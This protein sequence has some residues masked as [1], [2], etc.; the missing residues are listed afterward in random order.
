MDPFRDDFDVSQALSSLPT[1]DIQPCASFS[2]FEQQ[3]IAEQPEALTAFR[4]LENKEN[5]KAQISKKL[6]SKER[7]KR[8]QS[9]CVQDAKPLQPKPVV[10]PK[11]KRRVKQI[12]TGKGKVFAVG[13]TATTCNPSDVYG[14][15]EEWMTSMSR[16]CVKIRAHAA[17]H[18]RQEP[19]RLLQGVIVAFDK[20]WNLILRD[21]DEV[22]TP[23]L[24]LG[25]VQASANG[26]PASVVYTQAD[27]EKV[28]QRYSIVI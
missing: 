15:M 17:S 26:M 27:R 10:K 8:L 14:R 1:Y 4:Q 22:Y 20:H 28:L 2:A 9:I 24:R 25:N 18:T 5:E 19:N 23:P 21:I 16:V 7:F 3:L 6:S 11:E 12:D 13:N